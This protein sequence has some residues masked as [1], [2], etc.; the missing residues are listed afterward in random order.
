MRLFSLICLLLFFLF[1]ACDNKASGVGVESEAALGL[2]SPFICDIDYG[3]PSITRTEIL[4][5]SGNIEVLLAYRD[6]LPANSMAANFATYR[7]GALYGSGDSSMMYYK[8]A[9]EAFS[10]GDTLVVLKSARICNNIASQTTDPGE[11]RIYAMRGINL[12]LSSLKNCEFKEDEDLLPEL[13]YFAAKAL[14]D[15]DDIAG[16]LRYA[17]KGLEYGREAD[18]LPYILTNLYRIRASALMELGDDLAAAQSLD[19]AASQLNNP[20]EMVG[21]DFLDLANVYDEQQELAK[22]RGDELTASDAVNKA[23][24]IRKTYDSGSINEAHSLNNFGRIH[25]LEGNYRKANQLLKDALSLYAVHGQWTA[26]GT[27]FESLALGE[28][29]RGDTIRAL[30]WLD[31]AIVA[32]HGNSSG[33]NLAY[34]IDKSEIRDPLFTKARI[35]ARRHAAKPELVSIEEVELAIS[36]VDSINNLLRFNVRTERS[37]RHIIRQVRELYEEV[38]NLFVDRYEATGDARYQELALIYLER[39]KARVLRERRSQS[40]QRS[41]AD[42][43]TELTEEEKRMALLSGARNALRN[44]G[45]FEERRLGQLELQRLEQ[46]DWDAREK[47]YANLRHNEIQDPDFSALAKMSSSLGSAAALD[48]F[49]GKE[50]VFLA[51]AY[52]GKTEIKRLSILPDSLRKEIFAFM[53]EI[54][55]R[56]NRL[57]GSDKAWRDEQV[58]LLASR[59]H[60]LYQILLEPAFSDGDLAPRITI[61]PDGEISQLPFG[62]LLRAKPSGPLPAEWPFIVHDAVI[63]YHYSALSWWE[64][65]G[66]ESVGGNEM[67]VIAPEQPTRQKMIS[68]LGK[69]IELSSLTKVKQE[70]DATRKFPAQQTLWSGS[71]AENFRDAEDLS[72]YGVIHFSGH[73]IAFPQSPEYSFLAL[74]LDNENGPVLMTA[75]DLSSRRLPVELLVLSACETNRGEIDQGEGIIS[76]ARSGALAGANSVVSSL[77]SVPQEDK[78]LFFRKYYEMLAG[79]SRRDEAIRAAQLEVMKASPFSSHPYY[80]AAFQNLGAGEELPSSLLPNR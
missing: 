41:S 26:R 56:E 35:L 12:L 63:N 47:S 22:I 45:S 24:T 33:S 44:A 17:D 39:A 48:Y 13:H 8:Q 15:R 4:E 65:G 60:N 5:E 43:Q 79:N 68:P 10:T 58:R 42:Y 71:K 38:V 3:I 74:N 66:K 72:Q 23:Y 64:Q 40:I 46:L 9:L 51:V 11:R 7:L 59:G 75:A 29:Q 6:S 1:T 34:A 70:V 25:L 67:L 27:S 28:L 37:K 57:W 80:W 49:I 30:S 14:L 2:T 76:L 31:S 16:A 32:Y 61:L 18:M 62:A 73:G 53:G 50:R 77:W 55:A 19:S 52:Q 69:E 78:P 21:D 20:E 36:R 54:K